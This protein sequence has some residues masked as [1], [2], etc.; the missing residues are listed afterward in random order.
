MTP[1]DIVLDAASERWYA[2]QTKPRSEDEAVF[3]L[4]RRTP[5]PVFLPKVE[6]LRR[7]YGKKVR[8]VEP[9]F[10]S[11]LFIRMQTVP[12]QWQTVKW[13]PGVR[14]IL[15]CGGVPVPVPDEAIELLQAR[16]QGGVIRCDP[17]FPPGSSVR[18]THGP[19]AGLIGILDRPV[20]RLERVKVLI[21]L[22]Q[23]IAT[24]EVDIVDLELVS[25]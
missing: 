24:L 9:L 22:M 13:T 19:F 12:E 18:I 20:S 2:V 15:T 16:S 23:T 10:P 4:Q 3:W 17:Q 21:N 8:L 14:D 1:M 5:A 6:A 7:Q 11:Y 25:S